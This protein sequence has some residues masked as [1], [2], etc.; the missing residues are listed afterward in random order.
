MWRDSC[1]RSCRC[2]HREFANLPCGRHTDDGHAESA[3]GLERWDIRWA[4]VEK[5]EGVDLREVFKFARQR[6]SAI[7]A[8]EKNGLACFDDARLKQHQQVTVVS[9]FSHHVF[10][11]ELGNDADRVFSRP[12]T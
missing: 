6:P 11:A 5:D 9:R 3:D 2:G 4:G 12:A 7:P 10:I 8:T 1:R